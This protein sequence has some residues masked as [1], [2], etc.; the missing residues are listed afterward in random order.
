[1][2]QSKKEEEEEQQEIPP[3]M[4][5][6]IPEPPSEDF[7]KFRVDGS[8]ILED[9]IHQLKG[10]VYDPKTKK[11]EEKFDRWMNDKGINK[12]AHVVYACGINKN[13]FL[14]NLHK[15]EIMFKCK[16][17]KKQLSLLLFQ[18]YNDFEV[19]KEMRSLL[20]T[21]VVNTIHSALSRSEGGREAAQIS[22]A[23]QRIEVTQIQQ[24]DQKR[25]SGGL[26]M[27]FSSRRN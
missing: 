21:T 6:M 9:M 26:R 7:F 13:I 20:I 23:S 12:I 14:G 24:N 5:G 18:K 8:D 27:P 17:L 11:Y 25:Q 22:T 4:M 19:A 15:D 1:M 2:Q 3:P 16:M 10:E